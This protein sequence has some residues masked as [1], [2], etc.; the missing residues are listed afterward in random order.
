MLRRL[1]SIVLVMVMVLSMFSGT[2]GAQTTGTQETASQ[3]TAAETGEKTAAEAETPKTEAEPAQEPAQ[4][5]AAEP[6]QEELDKL[7]LA[8]QTYAAEDVST[9]EKFTARVTMGGMLIAIDAAAG[10]FPAGTTVEVT[11]VTSAVEG[12]VEDAVSG[13]LVAIRAY[14]I[15]FKDA[16]G[17]KVQPNGDVSVRFLMTT[18]TA[19]EFADTELDVFHMENTAAA[20]TAVDASTAPTAVALTA[21]KFSVYVVAGV[22][23]PE[24]AKYITYTFTADGTAVST[25]KVTTGDTLV[26]PEAPVKDGYKFTGWYNGETKFTGFGAVGTVSA[27]ASVALTAKFEPAHYIFFYDD[28]APARIVL[29]MSGSKGDVIDISAATFAVAADESITGWKYADGT[30]VSENKVTLGDNDVYLT[31]VVEKG[32]WVTYSAGAGASYLAPK[33]YAANAATVRPTDPTYAG[34][35]FGGWYTDSSYT[36]SAFAFG[37]AY[38]SNVTLYAKWTPSTNTKY[39]VIHM[40]Q[41]VDGTGYAFK[42]LQ[43][44][45]G[46]TGAMTSAT[47]KTY[48]GFTAQTVTQQ[49]IAGDGSTIVRIN[50]TRNS[51]T[52]TFYKAWGS[53]VKLGTFSAKYGE[54]VSAK[55]AAACTQYN[56]SM[57]VVSKSWNNSTTYQSYV[58]TM[59]AANLNFYYEEQSGSTQ[60]TFYYYTEVLSGQTGT[61]TYNGKS[62]VLANT[63]T[64]RG[65]G[66][67]S[68]PEDHYEMTGFTYENNV[69]YNNNRANFSSDNTLTFYYS[70]N[71]YSIVYHNVSEQTV[72]SKQ[73]GASLSGEGAALTD[74]DRPDGVPAGYTFGGWYADAG[75]T[76]PY[77]FSGTMP[78]GG[79]EVYA[80]W[81]APTFS[82]YAHVQMD[83]GD[84]P[85]NIGT[86]AYGSTIDPAGMPAPTAPAGDGW[87]FSSWC[88]KDANGNFLPFDFNT[89][90]YSD[91]TLYPYW[92]NGAAYG[93]TYALNGGTG[94]APVDSAPYAINAWARV[95]VLPAGTTNGNKVFV[96]WKN[97][98]DG[99]ICYPADKVKITGNLTLTAQWADP[100]TAVTI[101]YNSNAPVGTSSETAS[102]SVALNTSYSIRSAADLGWSFSGYVFK[103]WSTTAAGAVEYTAGDAV[104]LGLQGGGADTL[105]AVWERSTFTVTYDANGGSGAMTDT[106]SPYE[107]NSTVTVLANG[108]TAP[109]DKYFTGW[110]TAA[111]GSGTAYAPDAT[112]AISADTTL[113][114][115]W[116]AKT[117][118]SVAITGS[119]DTKIYTGSAQS[120]SGFDYTVTGAAKTAATVALKAGKTAQASGTNVGDYPMGLTG[121]DF[122][123]SCGEQ[124]K[125]TG[126][127]YTDGWLR[128]DPKPLTVA[129]TGSTDTKAYSGSAQSVSGFTMDTLPSGVSVT[130]KTGV[131]A[132]ATRTDVGTTTMG[133]TADSFDVTGGNYDVTL[134]VTD[135]SITITKAAVNV[136]ITGNTDTKVYNGSTQSVSG[137]DY[138][139]SAGAKADMIVTVVGDKSAAA[140]GKDVGNYPMGLT[141]NNFAVI[142][143]N[144][145]YAV[146]TVSYTDGSLTITRKAVTVIANNKTKA[147]GEAD[148]TFD[149]T[150]NGLVTGDTLN[151][152]FSRTAG[153]AVGS[154]TITPSGEAT[155]GNYTVTYATGTLTITAANT[156]TVTGTDGSKVYDGAA[157]STTATTNVTAGTTIEYKVGAG[158][159]T[160]TAPSITDV[161]S[162]TVSVRATNPNYTTATGSYTLAV[163]PRAV[164]VTAND[165]TKVYGAA[166]PTFDAAVTGL[167]GSDT[168][169]YALNREPGNDVGTYTITPSGEATQGNYAVTY[170]T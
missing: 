87:V 160:A 36:G 20:P 157:L 105:Y 143:A 63:V 10:V 40:L 162:V 139:V 53:S 95:A 97:S 119:T 64:I 55:F 23:M 129:V 8:A 43:E 57:W 155:Q 115:Q 27:D 146:G 124:Y 54:D 135:G 164:T 90:I 130:L 80:K 103:G 112:F 141:R 19:E 69:Q 41:T 26:E 50:Y 60:Y 102:Q 147:Y 125:I 78:A 24:T 166:D 142:S 168:V 46:T 18:A 16:G 94:T 132:S 122:A 62:Y 76:T 4:E 71:T 113:Y 22:I 11:E 144:T 131:S 100:E 116:A 148:P 136:T 51:Y 79:I 150:V 49:T 3:T 108:F 85:V 92:I 15:T 98:A 154:Y 126:V 110:N 167:L 45:T 117:E 68:T 52:V 145:N 21:N 7:S 48:T 106:H 133:L 140:S 67:V 159:W 25:Q 35:T 37:T 153:D 86:I 70:R 111:D 127:S 12:A 33:F 58:G 107:V 44:K 151:Y 161:G 120:V 1:Q 29:T 82:G 101:N 34:Y 121:D 61:K 47:S 165:K 5:P 99:A 83:G 32:Y 149:A 158:E 31:P 128:I 93:V 75:L 169:D 163:T 152:I 118:I 123:V 170:A 72:V 65:S 109:T 42:E 2:V 91:I 73:Y 39:T 88:T 30:A 56:C 137:F 77:V 17:S 134:N 9:A 59:P 28:A 74:A 6:T 89:K 96:G 114:A 66:L 84:T 156:L 138:T 104:N 13:E 81:S 38:G 14:D